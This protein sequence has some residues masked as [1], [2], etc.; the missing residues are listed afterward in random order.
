VKKLSLSLY[1]SE[2]IAKALAFLERGGRCDFILGFKTISRLFSTSLDEMKEVAE[3]LKNYQGVRLFLQWDVLMTESRFQSIFSRLKQ[4]GLLEGELFDAIRVQDPG[5]LYALKEMGLKKKIHLLVE[6]GNHNTTGL[7]AWYNF[8]PENIERMVLSP[9]LPSG[10]LIELDEELPCELEVLGLG[11]ILLFY[12]PRQ[13]VSPLYGEAQDG[14]HEVFGTS[15]ESPHKGFPIIENEHGTF[16]LNTKDQ[17]LFDETEALKR[18]EAITWRLDFILGS[19][20]ID[21]DQFVRDYE[22]G[23][24][25]LNHKSDYTRAVTKG[26]FRVNKTDVLFKKLKNYRLQDR[27]ESYLG[28]VVD[29]KKKEHVA[30]LIKAPGRTLA[31]GDHVKFLSPEGR[32]KELHVVAMRDALGNAL[33]EAKTGEIVFLGHIGGLSIRTMAFGIQK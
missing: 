7:K 27:G 19:A 2:D 15:E 29:V 3:R 30:L 13:L 28:E 16:M 4:S 21:F 24:D 32:E 25:F 23:G 9:E 31:L 26:F 12:T 8:W 11:P 14:R 33:T 20:K 5:A 10:T 1:Q 18:C 6:Q 22:E 17:F